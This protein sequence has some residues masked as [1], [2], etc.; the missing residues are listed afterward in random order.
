MNPRG[1]LLIVLALVGVG[2]VFLLTRSFL[3]Q[4]QQAQVAQPQAVQ[5]ETIQVLVAKRDLPLG[6]I[7]GA[8]DTEFVAWPKRA[9]RDSFIRQG[10]DDVAGQVLRTPFSAGVPLAQSA[11]VKPGERGFIAAALQ[12]GMRAVSVKVSE[13]TGVGGFIFPGDRVDL[14]ID[15][16]KTLT[17]GR[18]YK[19]AETALSNVRVLGVDQRS[20]VDEPTARLAKTVTLEVS[21]KMAEKVAIMPRLGV[22]TLSLRSLAATEVVDAPYAGNGGQVTYDG[23][24]STLFN[25]PNQLGDQS[26]VT[27]ARG[28]EAVTTQFISGA[29][30]PADAVS[31][32]TANSTAPSNWGSDGD[33]I[34]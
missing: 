28:N 10:G 31:G 24:V 17:D 16:E 23:D 1:I 27:I 14:I 19:V 9:V 8:E 3:S 12:P 18:T 15:Y 33:D 7:L 21:E 34:E 6:T 29:A 4:A 26:R 2:T 13:T 5:E 32:R 25:K 20:A 30:V 22:L 11:L